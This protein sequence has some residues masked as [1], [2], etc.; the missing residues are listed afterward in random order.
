MKV[1]I[2]GAG[3]AGLACALALTR[4]GVDVVILEADAIPGGMCRSVDLW[5]MK[6]DLGPHRFF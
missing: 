3:P 1:G 4:Q 6:V 5:G 2:I